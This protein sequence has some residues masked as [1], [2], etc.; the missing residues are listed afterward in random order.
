[1][2][3]CEGH[4]T[5]GIEVRARMVTRAAWSLT[6]D[7]NG[8]APSPVE[9]RISVLVLGSSAAVDC[10]TARVDVAV[11]VPET[12]K[13]EDALAERWRVVVGPRGGHGRLEAM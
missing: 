1:M 6:R 8:L 9:T 11:A 3:R 2:V 5:V 13:V 10:T 12:E 7:G 4:A